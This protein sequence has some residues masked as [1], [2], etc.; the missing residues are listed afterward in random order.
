MNWCIF[1]VIKKSLRKALNKIGP[2]IE[3]WRNPESIFQNHY[4]HYSFSHTVAF[5]YE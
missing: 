3:P 5:S 2:T 1:Y 4:I